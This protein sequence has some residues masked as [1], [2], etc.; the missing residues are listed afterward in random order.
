MTFKSKSLETAIELEKQGYEFYKKTAA[1]TD[2]KFSKQVLQSLAEQELEHKQ[3]FEE[4]AVGQ[5]IEVLDQDQN[6]DIENKIKEIFA[7][8]SKEEKEKW[9]D[10][11]TKTYEK[12][13]EMEKKTY[14][15]YK[16]M[17]EE[18][19]SKQ[20]QKF[21]E[22]LMKEESKHEESIQNV[23]YYITDYDWWIADDESQTWNWMNI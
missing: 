21:L 5:G 12:A 22:A 4:I 6:N 17:A 9:K 15:F 10:G 11:E 2:N 8:A 16:K 19:D 14:N 18:T 20:E 13:L 1:E 7:D 23:I 3:R